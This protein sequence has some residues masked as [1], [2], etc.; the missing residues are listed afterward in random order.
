MGSGTQS[1]YT[2][3]DWGRPDEPLTLEAPSV[4]PPSPPEAGAPERAVS[5]GPS[6]WNASPKPGFGAV[7]CRGGDT[8]IALAALIGALVVRNIHRMPVG[9]EDFLAFRLSIK[10]ILLGFAFVVAWRGVCK[11]CRLYDLDPWPAWR[12]EVGRIALASTLGVTAALAFVVTSASGAFDWTAIVLFWIGTMVGML[13]LRAG[14]RAVAAAR[15][16][17]PRCVLILGSGPRAQAM[18]RRLEA[19][20]QVA[21]RVV[22]FVDS[23]PRTQDRAS[24]ALLASLDQ[25]MEVLMNTPVDEVVIGLPFKS[26]YAQIERAIEMCEAFGVPVSL[27]ADPFEV[28]RAAYLP[29]RSGAILAVTLGS[30]PH[31]MRLLVKRVMDVVGALIALIVSTPLMLLTALAIK[32]TSSGPILFTQERYGYNRRRF[33]MYK[34]RSMVVDAEALLPALENLNQADGPLFKIRNDPRLTLIGKLLRR[35]SIDELPQLFNVL[36]GEMSLVGPRP[37]SIRDVHRFPEASLMRRFSVQPGMTGRWQVSGR[38]NL[39]YQSWATID[40][41]YVDQ[42][43]LLGDLK[44]LA[45][46][47]PAVLTGNGAD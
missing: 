19:D 36:R 43:S 12:L 35:S 46:T 13:T 29:R 32:L 2:F 9:I 34:F 39:D 30:A 8:A 3:L 4:P 41:E 5:D 21:C 33:R 7:V 40:L 24:G 1:R 20:Q 6:P 23:N 10:N 38:S 14:V 11:V 18:A 27:P 47:I 44:I 45:L 16:R 28:R 31:G 42:W 25:L 17:R 15:P 22:G 26:H 37:M